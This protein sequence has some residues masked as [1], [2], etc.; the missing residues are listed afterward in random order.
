MSDVTRLLN[1]IKQGDPDAT[2]QLLPL[3]YSELRELARARMASERADHTL[4]ATAL[5]HEAFVRLVDNDGVR[6]WESQRH[7]FAA[8]AQAMRR[9]LVDHARSRAAEKRGGDMVRLNIDSVDLVE[10]AS[11]DQLLLLNEALD[12]LATLDTVAAELV[13]LRYFAGLGVEQAAQVVGV[14][15]ATAYRHWK[16]A[17]AWLHRHL[18]DEPQ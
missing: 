4:Q 1:N 18:L 3:V 13:Q 17:R 8:A 2:S 6:Q 12:E 7:F 5:V 9:I 14:S 10:S 11:P 15:T 16:Y